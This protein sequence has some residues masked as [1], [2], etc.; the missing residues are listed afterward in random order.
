MTMTTAL[1]Y[2]ACLEKIESLR[3]KMIHAAAKHGMSHPLVLDYSQE[4][5]RAHNLA[6][7]HHN[8][9]KNKPLKGAF[10]F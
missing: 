7:M 2:D 10:E 6:M 5:D 3:E 8:H 9:E 4:L 1:T